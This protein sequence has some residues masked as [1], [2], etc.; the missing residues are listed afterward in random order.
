M[1]GRTE[2]VPVDRFKKVHFEC[3][4]TYLDVVDTPD[5]NPL[6]SPLHTPTPLSSSPSTPDSSLQTETLYKTKSGRTVHWAKK[7]KNV[8]GSFYLIRL[9]NIYILI[10]LLFVL[11]ALVL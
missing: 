3:D 1:N 10:F 11:Y 8:Q 6:Q 7:K 5:F 4:I 2:I 9:A